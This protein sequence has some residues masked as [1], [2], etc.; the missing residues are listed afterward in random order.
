MIVLAGSTNVTAYFSLRLAATGADATGLTIT[1]LDLTYVRSGATPAAKVDATALGA[2][3][4]AH[5]DNQAIEV[6]AANQ[7]GLYRVDWPDAAFAGGVREVIL[8]VRHASCFTEHLRVELN[9]ASAIWDADPASYDA[10]GTFGYYLDTLYNNSSASFIA[11]AVWDVNMDAHQLGD[12]S[13]EALM[14][15]K[16][17]LMDFDGSGVAV[18]TASQDAIA[19]K[20][21]SETPL[22]TYPGGTAGNILFMISDIANGAISPVCELQDN[23]ITSFAIATSGANEIA[24]AVWDLANGVETGVTPRGALRLN[25]AA[26]AGKVSGA[27]T[28]TETFRNVGD[29]KSRIVSTVD[30]SGNRTAVT[31]DVT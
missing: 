30:A 29:T 24:A 25:T 1:D 11:G 3:N 13:G 15:A 5:A 20:V 4:S 26:L 9:L 19:N 17:T 22:D 12:T 8:T 14:F 23:S 16:D 2:A 28:A 10:F 21:W 18:D 31:T 7:P 6:D 27:G